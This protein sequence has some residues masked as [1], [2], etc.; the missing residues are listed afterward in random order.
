MLLIG[1]TEPP[2]H[3]TT[4]TRGYTGRGETGTAHRLLPEDY[5]P[6]LTRH[7]EGSDTATC[8]G[9]SS[10]ATTT[11]TGYRGVSLHHR[12]IEEIQARERRAVEER[13]AQ[14]RADP[15][16]AIR[17]AFTPAPPMYHILHPPFS[18]RWS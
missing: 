9:E 8:R 7:L 17:A 18:T 5:N 4:D 3:T 11:V 10:Q 1:D 12:Q 14:M 16:A 15:A 6:P 2:R 13:L